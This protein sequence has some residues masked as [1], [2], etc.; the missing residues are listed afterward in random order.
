[1]KKLISMLMA[2]VLCL[3]LAACGGVDRTAAQSAMDS[4]ANALTDTAALLEEKLETSDV[5]SVEELA[6]S[7]DAISQELTALKSDLDSE[8]V[9]QERLD[10][11][12]QLTA[13]YEA[14]VKEIY[15]QAEQ[16]ED[17]PTS[18][19][20]VDMNGNEVTMETLSALVEA[21]DAVAVPY[22]EIAVA[23]NENGW[24]ADAQTAAE[25]EAL[26]N[27]LGFIGE[28]LT[29]DMALLDGSDFD[30]L[31]STL[32]SFLPELDGLAE[33]VSVPYAG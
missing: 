30:A 2:G 25:M 21:Y 8:D 7:L 23:V 14:Q 19:G 3:S 29:N 15:A 24:M 33:R 31:I 18:T 10:E 26:G 6:K 28:A 17:T 22:N 27:V 1:M 5:F 32:E 20:L 9:T 13:A 11:I 16:L 4:V 12:A